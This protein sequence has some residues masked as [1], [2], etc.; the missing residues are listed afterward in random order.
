MKNLT[1]DKLPRMVLS[2]IDLQTA[3]MASRVV[4]AAERLQVFRRLN[5]KA[6]SATTIGKKA[7]I[8]KNY[9]E[10]F[11]N[12]LVSMGLLKKRGHLYYNSPLAEKYFIR[13]MSIF[14]TRQYSREC[15]EEYE[16]LTVLEEILRKGQD[17]R[18]ILGKQRQDYLDRMKQDKRM[19]RDFTHMLY[20]A[21]QPDADAL[22][23]YLDLAG[24]GSVLDVG[25][26]SGGMS[27]SL[28]KRNPH[29]KACVLDIE[30]VCRIA[31]KIIKKEGMSSRIKTRVGDMS[32]RLPTGYDVI[33]LCDIGPVH[34]HLLKMAYESLPHHGMI[35][36]VDRFF[37]E[38]KTEPLDRLLSQFTTFSF[39]SQTRQQ[40]IIE[41]RIAGFRAIKRRRIYQD[42]WLITGLKR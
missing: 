14:W 40:V 18:S 24:Y 16:G 8:H 4:V 1:L 25:G 42:V 29:L 39:S 15:I 38:D 11:L 34:S 28:V 9:L 3:F 19:A 27:I 6:L 32:K 21:H 7:G 5:H 23:K 20:Y 36:C 22:A 31:R 33:M 30:P 41:L 2:K 35:V 17:Y 37:S 10:H 12:A 13:E 26:G